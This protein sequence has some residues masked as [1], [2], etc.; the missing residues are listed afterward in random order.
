M[1]RKSMFE[2]EGKEAT[3]TWDGKLCIHIGE[4]GKAKGELFVG[5][6]KP[7]CDPDLSSNADVQEI[8]QRCPSG[9]LSVEFADGSVAEVAADRNSVQVSYNGPL[10]VTGDLDI[11]DAP[12][13]VPGLKF[14]A[15]LCRCGQ[16][17]NK[18]YCDNSHESAGFQDH[19]AVG[20]RG[21]SAAETGGPLQIKFA[22]D[23]PILVNGTLRV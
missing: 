5:D 1:S 20:D 21:D 16:S 7:W 11:E 6:R 18:P 8:V 4:C 10:F 15:A 23:G 17:K 19:G 3:V 22:K 12:T 2:Y 14:R 13:E 9:A